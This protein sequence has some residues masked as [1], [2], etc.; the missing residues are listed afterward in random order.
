M[1][2]ATL[3]FKSPPKSRKYDYKSSEKKSTAIRKMQ[4]FPIDRLLLYKK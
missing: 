1:E 4:A 2:R 3:E